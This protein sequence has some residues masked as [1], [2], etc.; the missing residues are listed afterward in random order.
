MNTHNKILLYLAYTFTVFYMSSYF[1]QVSF[2]AGAHLPVLF[3]GAP[4]CKALSTSV[5]FSQKGQES[6][7]W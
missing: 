6:R 3:T 5:P 7:R 2:P 4:A 1:L